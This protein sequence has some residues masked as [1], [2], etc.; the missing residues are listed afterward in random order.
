MRDSLANGQRFRLVTLV[1]NMSRESPAIEVDRSL[2]GARV[3]AVLERLAAQRGL[4]QILQV[5]NGPEFTSQALDAWAHHHGVKLAFSR[6]GTPTDTPFIEAFNGR[7]RQE[8]LDQQWFFSLEEARECV[9]EW[10]RDYNTIRP[11]TALGNQ[12]PAAYAAAWHEQQTSRETSLP[13]GWTHYRGH[14]TIGS[15]L[16]NEWSPVR[17]QP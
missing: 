2:T 4:P 11:H 9:E 17:G 10:R 12:T 7:L 1:D 16:A 3:V 13:Y 6:P 8:C 5:D 14:I 15:A